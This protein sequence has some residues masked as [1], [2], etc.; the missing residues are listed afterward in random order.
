MAATSEIA[1]KTRWRRRSTG[2]IK[3]EVI[4]RRSRMTVDEV[5][6]TALD[7][8]NWFNHRRLPGPIGNILPAEA[9][10]THDRQ[11]VTL[12]MAGWFKASE[13]EQLS[14]STDSLHPR[15]L[16]QKSQQHEA[17]YAS[18]ATACFQRALRP[19]NTAKDPH[20]PAG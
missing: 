11:L 13:A 6:P 20:N 7:R 18:S 17:Y 8:V 1:A 19:T 10:A 12:P 15:H 2:F 16:P 14:Q 3:A 9:E 5:E 4:H